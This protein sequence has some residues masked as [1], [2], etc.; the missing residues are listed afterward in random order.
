MGMQSPK[1]HQEWPGRRPGRPCR[2]RSSR[3]LPDHAVL[4]ARSTRAYPV[5]APRYVI[6]MTD[7]RRNP[8]VPYRCTAAG[9]ARGRCTGT[10][11][12]FAVGRR[13]DQTP[14]GLLGLDLPDL[15]FWEFLKLTPEELREKLSAMGDT[16]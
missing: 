12:A 5:T 13:Q 9:A 7:V 15:G 11:V 3:G 14:Y 4:R 16:P 10:C 8:R 2:Q 6:M 1:W